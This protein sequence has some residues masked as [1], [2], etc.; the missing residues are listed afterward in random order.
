MSLTTSTQKISFPKIAFWVYF[1]LQYVVP[2]ALALP[3]LSGKECVNCSNDDAV[4]TVLILF[5]FFSFV[6]L[7]KSFP[8]K[9]DAVAKVFLPFI[10]STVGFIGLYGARSFIQELRVFGFISV[11]STLLAIIVW[12]VYNTIKD[13]FRTKRHILKKMGE[14]AVILGGFALYAIPMFQVAVVL[15]DGIFAQTHVNTSSWIIYVVGTFLLMTFSLFHY[16]WSP[17][18]NSALRNK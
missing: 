16:F 8:Q 2:T 11:S 14:I 6:R 3:F 10:I 12:V 4:I 1:I 7:K 18:N 15:I 9:P 13:A 5:L 17:E